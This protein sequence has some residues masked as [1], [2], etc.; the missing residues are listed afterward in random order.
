MNIMRTSRIALRALSRNKMRSF[1]TALGIIIGV[2]AVIAMVSLGEGAKRGVEERFNSLGTNLLNVF[3]G[4]RNCHGIRTG[5]GG[6]Q[7]LKVED[8]EAI[9]A[10][11]DAVKYVSPIG[12]HPGPGRLREQELEHIHPGRRGPLS[13]GPEL[14]AR[15]RDLLRRV[16]GPAPRPRSASSG[17]RSRSPCSR[18]RTRWARSSGSRGSRSGSWASSSPRAKPADSSTGTTSSSC[19]TRRS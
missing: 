5:G 12:Q 15:G 10:Q 4:S 13:R 19:P 18:T 9:A 14:G 1:L 3:P 7:S 11:C 6:W 16:P 17:S 8:A 2:G